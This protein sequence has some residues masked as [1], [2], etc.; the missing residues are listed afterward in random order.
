[1]KT[2]FE[3]EQKFYFDKG[4]FYVAQYDKKE[5]GGMMVDRKSVV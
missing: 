5:V 2:L 1:M 4:K 3:E